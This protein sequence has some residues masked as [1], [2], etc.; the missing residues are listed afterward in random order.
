[1]NFH[2]FSFKMYVTLKGI[3]NWGTRKFFQQQ[4]ITTANRSWTGLS[5]WLVCEGWLLFTL[6]KG[7]LQITS[8]YW[9]QVRNDFKTSIILSKAKNKKKIKNNNCYNLYN[10]AV[11]IKYDQNYLYGMLSISQIMYRYTMF[12]MPIV[13]MQSILLF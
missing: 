11:W 1:M 6:K 7:I 5:S 12:E 13:F 8:P 4:R 9:I 2:Y 10:N 3:R